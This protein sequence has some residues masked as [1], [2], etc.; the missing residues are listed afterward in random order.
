MK[1]LYSALA[2]VVL[3]TT[4][5]CSPKTTG[6]F[7]NVNGFNVGI[8]ST[9]PQTANDTMALIKLQTPAL[10]STLSVTEDGKKQVDA[11][12]AKALEA[13]QADAIAK[14]KAISPQIE[15]IYRYRLL[16]NGLAIVAPLDKLDEI[17]KL[18][19]VAYVETQ[20]SFTRP[21]ISEANAAAVQ[22]AIT[23]TS[24][25]F[26]GADQAQARGLRGQ[27][28][29]VGI[30]DTGIDYT[31]AMFGGAGTSDAYKAVDPSQPNAGFPSAKVAGGIDLVGTDYDSDS[32]DFSKRT[33]KVDGNPLDEGGHGSHVAGTVAG[34]GDG[35][36]TYDGVAPDA[37][38]YAIKVFGKNGSTGDAAVVA[39]L[40]YAADPNSDLDFTDALDVVNLSLGSSYGS[41]HI[42]YT[43]AMGRLS[44]AGTVVVASA[45]NSGDEDYIVGAPSVA[46]D[47]LSVA[48]SIDDMDQNYK[49]NAIEFKTVDEPSIVAEAIEGTVG[50]KIAAAGAVTGSLVAIGVA[51]KDLSDEV[52]AQLKGN[53]ALADR[54]AVTFEVKVKRAFEAGA[55]GVVV[56]NNV[57]GDPIAMGGEKTYD[58]PAVM[59]RKD[60]GDKL[61]AAMA[62]G[63]ATIQFQ[64]P[65]KIE[66]PELIDTITGF[67]S[68]GPRSLDALLK[69]EIAAPGSQIISAKMGGG[70]VGVQMSGTSMA[71]PH[72]AGVMALV[73]QAHP[74]LTSAELKS[75]VMS[76]AKTMVDAEKQVYPL[77]RQGAGRIQVMKAI[78]A[79]VVTSPASLS[80]G[81][82]TIDAKKTMR[83][84]LTVKNLSANAQSFDVTYE[85]NPAMKIV[86]PA[87]LA[88]APNEVKTL[89][90][91]FLVDTATLKET[92]TELDGLIRFNVGG[93]EMSRIPVIGIANKVSDVQVES[94]LVRSTGVTNAQGAAVDLSL[95]NASSHAG[96]VYLFNLL[97]EGQRKADPFHDPFMERGCN[98]QQAGYR[99]IDRKGTKVLQFAV[100]LFEPMTTWDNCEVSILID[101]DQDGLPDQE[102]VGAKQDHLK[103]LTASEFG[104]ILL[105]APKAR[106]IRKQFELDTQAKKKEPRSLTP[107][108]S[109]TCTTCSRRTFRRSPSS[110]PRSRS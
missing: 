98:L 51:D 94:L 49:F 73:K 28:L 34:H 67:S 62:R 107:T 9:R 69:P 95:K 7:K 68:K 15:I 5:G 93:E 6:T 81:E 42:L 80:L 23:K 17:R 58:I 65:L 82:I 54:G 29:K 37:L 56:A 87:T 31:H 46:D 64:T 60:L 40:E 48:A 86:G 57:D 38:L 106:E 39:A 102:L 63:P 27:G 74:T 78:D 44:K 20:T 90:F 103:G 85:S 8:I 30:I 83:R 19:N 35:V 26:I 3:F 11:N 72:M 99:V 110:K 84:D 55:I 2:A 75:L 41:P 91:S 96:D 47:A 32:A 36:N 100:K 79:T 101:S 24:V 4:T 104:S 45:G 43:E 53:V 92:S 70:A 105:D 22:A 50:K 77:S 71:S 52:K 12:V 13:E 14:L 16:V 66:K 88:L 97:G 89:S 21:V 25:Q 59:I 109:S 76:T 61:K 1:A 108:P 10:F 18:G 33:P